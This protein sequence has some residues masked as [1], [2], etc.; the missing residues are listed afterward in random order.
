[1]EMR[2]KAAKTVLRAGAAGLFVGRGEGR[3]AV[4]WRLDV[5][6]EAS[7]GGRASRKRRRPEMGRGRPKLFHYISAGGLRQLRRTTADDIAECRRRS[8]LVFLGV[9]AMIWAVFYF[10][11]PC[12]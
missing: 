1:M 10:V 8:F 4:G 9:L 5:R 11:P 7:G 12:A 3:T 6:E 2:V